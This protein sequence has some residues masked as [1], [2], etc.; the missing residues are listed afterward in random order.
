M[1]SVGWDGHEYVAQQIKLI[2]IERQHALDELSIKLN[3]RTEQY[4]QS[5]KT[6]LEK[7]PIISALEQEK[8]QLEESISKQVEEEL[9]KRMKQARVSIRVEVTQELQAQLDASSSQLEKADSKI[10]KL[11]EDL[12]KATEQVEQWKNMAVKSFEEGE[13]SLRGKTISAWDLL[14]LIGGGD[15]GILR[16][17]SR[18]RSLEQIDICELDELLVEIYTKMFPDI[19]IGYKDPRVRL[20]FG[21]GVAFLKSIPQGT[22]DVVILDAF[23]VM[24]PDAKE[25]V[26][27]GFLESVA[28]ALRPGGVLCAPADSFWNHEFELDKIIAICSKF[29][30]GSVNYAWSSVPIYISGNIGYMLCSTEGPAVDFKHPINPLDENENSGIANEPLKYYNTEVHTAA[31]CLPTFVTR[32]K[33]KSSLGHVAHNYSCL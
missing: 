9:A 23:D 29:F 10:K 8:K 4:R 26:D 20:H 24:G 13:S 6:I 14:L 32:Q 33:D 16:E 5:L 3:D 21:D 28:K 1:Y 7:D 22:Y 18:H 15:G 27:E 30:K 17:A 19:A 31:F 11:E 25:V 2:I 12:G